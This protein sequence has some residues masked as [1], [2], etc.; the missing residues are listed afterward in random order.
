[1]RLKLSSAPLSTNMIQCHFKS[2][3]GFHSYVKAYI[4]PCNHMSVWFQTI[5][6]SS[7]SL[8]RLQI[9]N[10]FW[11]IMQIGFYFIQKLFW[12]K[13]SSTFFPSDP[14]LTFPLAHIWYTRGVK[15]QCDQFC[16]QSYNTSMVSIPKCDA[17]CKKVQSLVKLLLYFNVLCHCSRLP[18]SLSKCQ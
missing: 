1:M 10:N 7:C 2:Y 15:M 16:E 6:S 9:A 8:L 12:V 13:V 18:L 4:F 3:L 11:N 5:I 17:A 14:T